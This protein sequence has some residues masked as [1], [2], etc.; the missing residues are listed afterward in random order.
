MKVQ[1]KMHSIVTQEGLISA[2][3]SN[4]GMHINEIT[5]M[6]DTNRHRLLYALK[7]GV[8][9]GELFIQLRN[10]FKHVYTASY[11]ADNYVPAI[12][13]TKRTK[14]VRGKSVEETKFLDRIKTIDSLW[15]AVK[16]V[17]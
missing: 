8:A 17:K 2:V 4:E 6:L 1:E 7:E 16:G 3:G 12:V 5:S 13:Y 14:I 9:S 15:P 11:A 10:R